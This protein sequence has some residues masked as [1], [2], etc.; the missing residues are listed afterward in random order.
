[1]SWCRDTEAN[2]QKLLEQIERNTVIPFIGA[3]M[4]CPVYPTW[5][6]YL[7]MVYNP[8]DLTASQTVA[9]MLADEP[10]NFEDI[11]QYLQKRCGLLFF[12]RTRE[13]FSYDKIL[14]E[15][16][17]PVLFAIPQLFRGPIITTNLDQSLEWLYRKFEIPLPVGLANDQ[18]FICAH[19]A[20]S[21][22]CLWKIHGDIDK[23]ESWVL[24][25]DD[26]NR[27]YKDRKNA[28]FSDLFRQ[29]LQ[30]RTLL[31]LGS[32]LKSDKVVHLL[33]ELFAVNPYIRH[34]AI[35]PLE[36]PL[37]EP[38]SA[39]YFD[40]LSRLSN[41]G[42]QPLWYPERDYAA[43]ADLVWG[44]VKE[45]GKGRLESYPSQEATHRFRGYV[46]RK[47]AL[48]EISMAF[49]KGYQFV[50]LRGISGIGKTTL[51]YAYLSQV[52]ESTIC[53]KCSDLELFKQSL[54]EFL[55][56]DGRLPQEQALTAKLDYKKLFKEALNKRHHYLVLF[57][58]VS[59]DEIFNFIGSLPRN[60]KY[61]LTTCC[62]GAG[63]LDTYLL[64]VESMTHSEA[65]YILKTWNPQLSGSK[66]P[67]ETDWLIEELNVFFGG[68]PLALVQAASYMA[69]TRENLWDYLNLVRSIPDQSKSKKQTLLKPADDLHRGIYASFIMIYQTIQ[70]RGD[71]DPSYR[72]ACNILAWCA[73]LHPDSISVE[74]LADLM[75][76]SGGDGRLHL[77]DGFRRLLSYSIIER[78]DTDDTISIKRIIQKLV[79]GELGGDTVS[80]LKTRVG[81]QLRSELT[82]KALLPYNYENRLPYIMHAQNLLPMEELRL[83][84]STVQFL[85]GNLSESA[86]IRGD[87]SSAEAYLKEAKSSDN[88]VSM[89]CD[90]TRGFLCEAKG[91]YTQV[92]E[93]IESLGKE[94]SDWEEAFRSQFPV[95]YLQ[96]KQLEAFL[97]NDLSEEELSEKALRAAFVQL[98]ICK[99]QD[100]FLPGNHEYEKLK[101]ELTNID[102]TLYSIK[103]DMEQAIAS[104][105]SVLT[106]GESLAMQAESKNVKV[107][108]SKLPSYV[109]A[110]GN[111]AFSK[112]WEGESAQDTIKALEQQGE[113]LEQMY[114]AHPDFAFQKYQLGCCYLGAE[115]DIGKQMKYFEEALGIFHDL[116]CDN[117][118]LAAQIHLLCGLLTQKRSLDDA[119]A[120]Y[121]KGLAVVQKL[122]DSPVRLGVE[123]ALMFYKA[124]LLAKRRDPAALEL[125][126]RLSA[127][128]QLPVSQRLSIFNKMNPRELKKAEKYIKKQAKQGSFLRL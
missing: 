58:D 104:Y 56:W 127:T 126:E 10:C 57:D 62:Q 114:S 74:F 112:Y 108:V 15:K 67:E 79:L 125:W 89:W 5:K 49:A 115:G 29:F 78:D 55:K 97:Y 3:G 26:Y 106:M 88:I 35:L 13:I 116:N 45:T 80:R 2:R 19:M 59:D 18:S 71:S 23:T 119:C 53:L 4:S 70:D 92:Y 87:F 83:E 61:L 122:R 1:M 103:G 64:S 40:E 105:Q 65:A 24:C 90:I 109:Y 37:Q 113:W 8:E 99:K 98:E 20:Q 91:Q 96:W 69:E 31:F 27:L 44:L 17:N 46:E 38:R 76:L 28:R 85:Y 82:K 42:I 68:I 50:T 6:E 16:I 73:V 47:A 21:Q 22:P 66:D 32:S 25:T 36:K 100:C 51:A 48:K 101:M 75:G 94:K 54:Y 123:T 30:S 34:F 107:D 72:T 117:H 60:G 124:L 39:E 43:L 77:N 102:G 33:R 121:D 111:L 84:D 86:F 14:Q 128:R 12:D 7:K 81:E 11:L 118:P 110:Y 52:S 120:H 9:R 95:R 41:M 93:I 63:T